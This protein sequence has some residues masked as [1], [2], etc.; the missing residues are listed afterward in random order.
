MFRYPGFRGLL[1][2]ACLAIGISANAEVIYPGPFVGTDVTY[3]DVRESSADPINDPEPLFGDPGIISPNTLDFD[4]VT[5][6]FAAFA[7]QPD[8]TDGS[9]RFFV[10][11]NSSDTL[12]QIS[13]REGGDYKFTLG[14]AAPSFESV[15]ATL[16]VFIK[17]ANTEA[18][19]G[20]ASVNFFESFD[21]P[22]VEEGVWS[23]SLDIDVSQFERTELLVELDNN[24]TA[25]SITG[26]TAFIRKKEFSVTSTIPEPASLMLIVA[27]ATLALGRRPRQIA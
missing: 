27:G 21:Q 22:N 13:F 12:Q 19:L 6:G 15:S 3:S 23:L 4:P 7:P 2:A 20:T 8:T 14:S 11:S 26:N 9:L 18:N 16:R 25:S 10:E 24:L 5:E 17:D 1:F